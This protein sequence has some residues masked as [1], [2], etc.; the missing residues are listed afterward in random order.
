MIEFKDQLDNVLEEI[1]SRWEIPGMGVGIVE[2][3]E[4]IYTRF[5]GVQNLATMAPV[6]PRTIFCLQSISKCFVACAVIQLVEQGMIQLDEP[7]VQYLP[8]FKLSDERYSRITIRQLL[9]HTSG[10]PDMDEL[11]YNDFVFHPEVDKGA[12]E[13]YVRSLDTK[14][15]VQS[16]GEG[17]WYSN[18][19]YDILGDL[20]AKISG[21]VF[22]E[23]MEEHI[24]LPAG[25]P[26]ST[27][28][29]ADVKQDRLAVPHLRAP[30][31]IVN[32]IYPYHR[33]DAPAS[34]LHSS[35]EDVCHWMIGCLNMGVY[36]QERFLSASSYDLMWT[37][38]VKRGGTQLKEY[39]GLGWSLGHFEGVR[40]ISHGGGGFGWTGNLVLMPERKQ[41]AI[42]LSNEESSAI[43]HLT[44]AVLRTMLG[45]R[46]RAGSVSWMLPVCHAYQTG[47]K[48][49]AQDRISEL[50]LNDVKDYYFNEYDLITLV[51]QLMGAGNLD[52]AID[53][54]NLNILAFPKELESY[55]RLADIHHRRSED[56]LAENILI[57]ALAIQPGNR[58]AAE[59]LEKVRRRGKEDR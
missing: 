31:M 35:I 7:I 18:L 47:G 9:S 20:I 55:T 24:L 33:A 48:Q 36:Q 21:Q 12:V 44:G 16:P 37:P 39:M 6:T 25:M 17:F 13:R 23:Y 14:K 2:N 30:E 26:D 45:Q 32:P 15:L 5:S 51:F 56:S 10:L 42:I 29:L 28:L 8:Y 53:M 49:A 59:L 50:K 34:F 57:N 11:E 54:L 43:F 52:A 58:E 3:D 46:V 19:G 38:A 22:E 4:I 27:F 41:A 1:R 40:T